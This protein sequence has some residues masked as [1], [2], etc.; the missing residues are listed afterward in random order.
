MPDT[1]HQYYN[2][3][4]PERFYDPMLLTAVRELPDGPEWTHEP[5]LNGYRAQAEN[6]AGR[7]ALSSRR[8]NSFVNRYPLVE[9]ELPRALQGHSAILDGELVGMDAEERMDIRE[10]QRKRSRA[11]LHV[12]DVLEVDGEPV[13][14]QPWEYRRGRL[15]ALVLE[16]DHVRLMRTEDRLDV[17]R[18]AVL[19]LELEGIVSK[20]RTSSYRPGVR[21][22]DWVKL[23]LNPAQS[24]FGVARQIKR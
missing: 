17:L 22:R 2:R 12:F 7:V 4:M 21:S 20:R 5:K 1:L 11:T 3:D 9:Q 18:D 8:G 14:R 6:A 13:I 16:T 15:E 10:L 23:V 19:E 24:G